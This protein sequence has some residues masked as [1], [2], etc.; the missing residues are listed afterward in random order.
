MFTNPIV[1]DI[2]T[3]TIRALLLLLSGYLVR[4][5]IWSAE[6]ANSYV[7]YLAGAAATGLLT[8][9]WALW[10][11]YGKRIKLLAALAATEPMTEHQIEARV[12]N[13]AIPNPPASTP[14]TEVPQA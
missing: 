11:T 1:I 3:T 14:K 4:K 10:S 13:Q 6:Q 5:G 2:L 12:A 9:A 7:G 8:I